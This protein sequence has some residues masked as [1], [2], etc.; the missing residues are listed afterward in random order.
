MLNGNSRC[1][2]VHG[3]TPEVESQIYAFLQGAVYCWC[4]NRPNEWFSTGFSVDRE[5]NNGRGPVDYKVSNGRDDQT[6]IEFKLASNTKLEKNLANQVD[7]YKTAN[8]TDSALTAI[9]YFSDREQ[10][11]VLKILKALQLEGNENIVLIDASPKESA[12]NVG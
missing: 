3:L 2:R 10:E 8:Q 7:V 11:R 9:L 6:L 1:F 4:K 5:V 12:S